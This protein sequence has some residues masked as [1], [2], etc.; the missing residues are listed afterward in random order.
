V[1]I[2]T[3]LILQFSCNIS[4]LA[5]HFTYC[6]V[7][8]ADTMVFEFDTETINSTVLIVQGALTLLSHLFVMSS[9]P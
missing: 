5:V 6:S 3:S 7:S 4:G 2:I 1:P 8:Q 9:F